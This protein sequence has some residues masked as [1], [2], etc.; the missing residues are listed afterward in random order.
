MPHA[1]G[2][3]AIEYHV[4]SD[5]IANLDVG[6]LVALGRGAGRPL[7]CLGN[8]QDRFEKVLVVLIEEGLKLASQGRIGTAR[9]DER[10]TFVLWPL[11]RFGEDAF[12]LP[13]GISVHLAIASPASAAAATAWPSTTRA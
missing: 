5:A 8:C 12:G 3:K 6:K 10:I 9:R 13:P 4:R 11:Q 2:A 7:E 1:A